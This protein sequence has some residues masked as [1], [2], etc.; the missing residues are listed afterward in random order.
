M[1]AM[2]RSLKQLATELADCKWL[3]SVPQS[4][5]QV[6][7]V[8]VL[9]IPAGPQTRMDTGP[10]GKTC[11]CAI[12]FLVWPISPWSFGYPFCV[13]IRRTITNSGKT[14]QAYYTYRLVEGVR[15]GHLVKQTTRLNLGSHFDLPQANWALL[16]SRIDALKRGQEAL[17]L[18]PVP[19]AVEAMAQRCA[20][21]LIARHTKPMLGKLNAVQFRLLSGRDQREPSRW[22][23]ANEPS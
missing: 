9:F 13:F 4:L 22:A 11:C 16:A 18:A 3:R 5:A 20:A 10:P 23:D 19:E 7:H 17:Q 15:S 8:P 12:P 21:Q 6:C 14:D 2:C 1:Y